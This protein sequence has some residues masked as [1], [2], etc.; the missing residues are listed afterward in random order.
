[1]NDQ[2]AVSCWLKEASIREIRVQYARI[3]TAKI[4]G[5]VERLAFSCIGRKATNVEED[6]GNVTGVGFCGGEEFSQALVQLLL[7]TL[8]WH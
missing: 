3:D 1:M 7:V 4:E 5:N 6:R 8:W 2:K